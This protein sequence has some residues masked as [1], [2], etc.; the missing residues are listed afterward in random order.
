MQSAVFVELAR[1]ITVQNLQTPLGPDILFGESISDA[2][3]RMMEACID[4]PYDPMDRASL[5]VKD[6]K[7]IG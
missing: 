1:L 6:G 4:P 3:E 5:V 2:H 7:I